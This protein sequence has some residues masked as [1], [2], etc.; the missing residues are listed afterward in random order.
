MDGKNAYYVPA[1][2][3]LEYRFNDETTFKEYAD[4]WI[5]ENAEQLAVKTTYRYRSLLERINLGIGHIRL[6]DLQT[7]HLRQFLKN[8]SQYGVNKRTGKYLSEKTILHHYRLISVILQQAVRD[9]LISVN[10]ASKEHMKAPRVSRHETQSLQSAD[11]KKLISVLTTDVNDSNIRSKTAILLLVLTGLR[12]GELAGLQFG[13]L[14][15]NKLSI[16]RTVLYT[17]SN[18]IYQ[19]EPKTQKSYR[20]FAV[21]KWVVDIFDTY[22]NWYK[23]KYSVPNDD[24]LLSSRKLFCQK[25]GSLI[26]PDTITIW[27]KKFSKQ[28]P[29]IQNFT[30]HILRHTYASM[31]MSLGVPVKEIS[32]RLGHS[33]LTTICDI[34]THSMQS[35]D[36]VAAMALDQYRL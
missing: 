33:K 2:V 27:C 18:G 31:L 21:S 6:K 13:D 12:R 7:Y 36:Y 16:H 35:A 20:T 29:S 8:L 23:G 14:Q 15:D 3:P 11:F 4:V 26:H 32:C 10:V 5:S 34:Y 30:P 17:P 1:E 9:E 22:Q 28:N 25:D 19:K 24:K